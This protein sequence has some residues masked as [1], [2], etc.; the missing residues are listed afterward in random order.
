MCYIKIIVL[1]GRVIAFH[2]SQGHTLSLR[3]MSEFSL[4][5]MMENIWLRFLFARGPHSN[6]QCLN[7]KA[8][9]IHP[10]HICLSYCRQDGL[11]YCLNSCVAS[12]AANLCHCADLLLSMDAAAGVHPSEMSAGILCST[13]CALLSLFHIH[14]AQQKE[15]KEHL[16]GPLETEGNGN[17]IQLVFACYTIFSLFLNKNLWSPPKFISLSVFAVIY[18]HWGFIIRCT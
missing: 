1:V 18:A 16:R 9:C 13:Q 4:Q 10:A 5:Q 6:F 17:S 12:N 2:P 7:L 15:L 11:L 14:T 8:V 3:L